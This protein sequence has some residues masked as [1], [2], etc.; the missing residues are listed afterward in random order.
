MFSIVIRNAEIYDGSGGPPIRGQVALD[1]DRIAAVGPEIAGAAAETIDAGGQAVAP[2]FIDIHSHTDLGVFRTPGAESKVTQGVTT[3]VTGNC[4]IAAFPVRP[5]RQGLLAE[6]WRMHGGQLPADGLTWTDFARYAERLERLPLGVNLAPLAAHGPLRLAAMGADDRGPTAA[7][8]EAMQ[9]LLAEALAQG[10]WGMSSG[11]IYPPGSFA[12]PEELVALGAVLA[13][14]RALYAS[15]IRN[16]GAGLEASL[17]EAIRVGRESGARVQVSH[18]KALGR[19]SWG[20]GRTALAALETARAAG[21]DVAADQYPYEATSTTLAA[22]VPSWAHAGGVGRMLARLAAPE[23]T[24]RLEEEIDGLMAERGGPGR[25]MV[26]GVGS[27]KHAACSGRR[28]AE[29]AA[30]WGIRPAAAVRRLLLEERGVVGA[31]YFSLSEE[32]VAAIMRSD[33]VAVGSDGQGLSAEDGAAESTHPRSYGTF[34]R[35]LGRYVREQGLLGLSLAVHKM[36]AVPAARLGMTDRGLLRPGLVADLVLFDPRR[37]IDQAEFEEPHRYAA[38]I[39]HVLVNGRAVLR[40]G[41]LTGERA[42][43]VLRRPATADGR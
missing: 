24:A 17:E 13:R 16:E 26:A 11:L 9:A 38:G 2:G 21:V 37:I 19:A 39:S 18:L 12:R 33:W 15:H 28:V 32:D 20:K 25:E 42:G 8:L 5:E 29:I 27:P 3:E 1:G 41:R 14:A 22:V 7:E 36:T 31:V 6:N 35:V 34:P 23:L 30:A 10:A 4:G 43:R 40:D